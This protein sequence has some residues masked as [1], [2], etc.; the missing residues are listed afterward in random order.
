MKLTVNFIFLLLFVCAD[1]RSESLESLSE[2]LDTNGT[3]ELIES[4]QS[5]S[6]EIQG[7]T[8]LE[9]ENEF[10]QQGTG[11][12]I[13]PNPKWKLESL[14]TGAGI[15]LSLGTTQHYFSTFPVSA[16]N[17]DECPASG[18]SDGKAFITY[19]N[20]TTFNF[21]WSCGS[22]GCSFWAKL[23]EGFPECS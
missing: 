10:R 15:R 19:Q 4:V 20:G 7:I 14:T 8:Y 9:L 18:A 21:S 3:E 16:L 23:G 1:V 6:T 17:L 11:E 2:F 5:A 22:A 12:V 13:K